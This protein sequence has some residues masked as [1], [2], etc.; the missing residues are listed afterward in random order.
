[1][2]KLILLSY[3]INPSKTKQQICFEMRHA[4]LRKNTISYIIEEVLNWKFKTTNDQVF[5]VKICPTTLGRKM[6]KA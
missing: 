2:L 6:C 4:F 1:M 5:K 3:Y